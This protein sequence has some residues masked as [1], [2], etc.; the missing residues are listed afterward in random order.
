MLHAVSWTLPTQ[1]PGQGCVLSSASQARGD[2]RKPPA[3][4]ASS[5][6]TKP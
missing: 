2:L 4:Y 3:L 1:V 6:F 5:A